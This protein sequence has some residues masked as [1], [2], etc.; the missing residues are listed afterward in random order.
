[1]YQ[2][3]D[4]KKLV[5][6]IIATL[7]NI[8]G[9]MYELI[10]KPAGINKNYFQSLTKQ[11]NDAGKW[12][13]KREIASKIISEI[14]THP[15][16]EK[17]MHSIIKT[18]SEFNQFHIA[19]DE[20]EARAT[21]QKAR[22]VLGVLEILEKE[23][24]RKREQAKEKTELERAS[25][26]E[27]ELAKQLPLLLLAFDSISGKSANPQLRGVMLEDIVNRLFNTYD[28]TEQLTVVQA[29]RR[30]DSGEQ[31]DG[32]FKLDGWHYIV[33]MKWTTQVSG[34]RDLDSLS[35]K[36][37]RSGK[38]TMGVFLSVNGWSSHV[39]DLIKQNPDKSILLM[40]GYDLRIAL[41]RQVDLIKMLHKKLSKLNLE[42]EPF[43][44][45]ESMI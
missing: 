4:T 31:I 27:Q 28:L 38:Q 44:G 17:I 41:T 42:S 29:F 33:E 45:A 16:Y 7:V 20:Y 8:K 25:Q 39:V 11:K 12:L 21:V 34:I 24:T 13:T 15:S 18:A 6:E 19:K 36:V 9:T 40:S 37:L 22:E 3:A 1:M 32:A 5:I 14:E 23:E 2:S 10:L 35:G 30:N 43:F 26:K